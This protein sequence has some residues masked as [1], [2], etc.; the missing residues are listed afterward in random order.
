MELP[1]Q[2]TYRGIESSDALSRLIRREG[3]KLE[4]FFNR[5][6]SC[7][8]LVE[9]EQ[10]HLREGAPFRL[11]IDL[12][13]PGTELTVDTAR[14]IRAP[15]ADDETPV[16]SKSDEIDAM[17]KDPEL[18]VRDAFRRARRRLQ[19]YTRRAR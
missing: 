6:V 17:H 16:R 1:L 7:R 10:R 13:V 4:L 19:D 14:S 8:V 11:R 3:A 9:R 12:E 15:G 18:T 5:I 2:I